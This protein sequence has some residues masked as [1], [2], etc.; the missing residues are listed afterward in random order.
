MSEL[1]QPPADGIS[2]RTVT[3]AMAWA[4]PVIAIAAPAPAFAASGN[5]PTI[6]VGNAY[7]WPGASCNNF[8]HP[9]NLDA[10]KGYVLTAKVVNN[11]GKTIFLYNASV[12]TNANV[13]FDVV[14]IVPDFG[15][16]INNGDT[17]VVL[18]FAN[19]AS[20]ANLSFTGTLTVGWGHNFPG[21]DPDNH[22]PVVVPFTVNC[23]PTPTSAGF[24]QCEFPFSGGKC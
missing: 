16:P 22:P 3:K 19:G 6:T 21:P 15:T 5:P 18:I 2:R 9:A 11:T 24:S 8:P 13:T 14:G 12:A 20:S 10:N 7:K 23:T 1:E 17:V 4:V